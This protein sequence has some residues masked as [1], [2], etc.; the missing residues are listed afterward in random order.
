MQTVA[1]GYQVEDTSA[2][3]L[4]AT[5][6]GVKAF[7][8]AKFGLSV[9][10]G[11]YALNGRGEWVYYVERVPLDTYRQRLG[12]FNPVRFDAEEWADLMVEAGQ[13]FLT[14]TSKHHDGFC[15]WDTPSTDW[16]IT[17]TPFRRDPLAELAVALRDRGL[18]LCFY[19]SIL[20]W[21]HPAYR[22]DWPAYVAYYQA[23][24]RELCT[25]FGKIGGIIFDGYWPR[26][27]FDTPDEQVYFPARGPWDLAGTYDLIHS[28]QPDAVVINNTHV[29]PLKGEDAQVWE[30]D[31]PGENT[32]GFNTTEIGDKPKAVWWNLNGGWAY[33]PR[34]HAVKDPA[35]IVAK[36]HEA[37]ARGATFLLN[38]G[39]RP[40]GDIHPE[41]ASAL[42]RIGQL[43][44][45]EPV[46][47]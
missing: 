21:T 41:E 47:K 31:M 33:N 42:R 16:K 44:R 4:Q 28:L 3:R 14:I 8:E 34:A 20:D 40:W 46:T 35:D 10:W 27:V 5:P 26:C 38:V 24:V 17:R 39:P 12:Q 18:S 23:H 37:N 7:V 32:V 13:K 1:T 9:H 11:L 45:Q 19:Y 43:L 30:L 15:L 22:N 36:L 25:R 29:L 2:A 6:E